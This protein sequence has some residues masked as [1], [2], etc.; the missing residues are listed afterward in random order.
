[1]QQEKTIFDMMVNLVTSRGSA[2]E[3]QDQPNPNGRMKK[4][5]IKRE[6]TDLHHVN[7][8]PSNNKRYVQ[9]NKYN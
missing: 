7:C 5:N 3:D 4:F 2:I 8:R 6:P 1:M 9:T